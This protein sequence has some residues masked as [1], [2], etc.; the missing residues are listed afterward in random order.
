MISLLTVL[1][2]RSRKNS[3]STPERLFRRNFTCQN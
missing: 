3:T 1:W 2:N